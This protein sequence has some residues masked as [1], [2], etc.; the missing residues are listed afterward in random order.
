MAPNIP[1]QPEFEAPT[2]SVLRFAPSTD[3]GDNEFHPVAPSQD[4]KDPLPT[5]SANGSDKVIG[6]LF[7][8]VHPQ[9]AQNL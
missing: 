1:A 6:Q 2:S 7:K 5:A 8:W 3:T 9:A 4:T